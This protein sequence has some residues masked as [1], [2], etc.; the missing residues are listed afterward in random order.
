M[1]YK[2]MNKLKSIEK[3]MALPVRKANPDYDRAYKNMLV[4]LRFL[5]RQDSYC[6]CRIA[7]A[8][9]NVKKRQYTYER[10]AADH[11]M[12]DNALRRLRKFLAEC[13]L[14]FLDLTRQQLPL[15]V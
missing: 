13:F 5:D 8:L 11:G 12:T 1:R 10:I 14:Y 3:L 6:R 15:A 4:T 9:Y 2:Q 7:E